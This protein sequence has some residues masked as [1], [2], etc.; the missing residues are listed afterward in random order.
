MKVTTLFIGNTSGDLSV[1][2]N[3]TRHSYG[4][5]IIAPEEEG[6]G[7][8]YLPCHFTRGDRCKLLGVESKIPL[9]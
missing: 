5:V 1:N 8:G 7:L 3:R 4:E 6:F 2:Q 9:R